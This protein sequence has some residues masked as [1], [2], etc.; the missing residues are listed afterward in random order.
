MSVTWSG[1]GT[2]PFGAGRLGVSHLSY[3]SWK[4]QILT[5]D[6]IFKWTQTYGHFISVCFTMIKLLNVN[7][8]SIPQLLIHV[9]AMLV[10]ILITSFY[11]ILLFHHHLLLHTLFPLHPL[12]S[13]CTYLLFAI[14]AVPKEKQTNKIQQN[15]KW[16]GP[17]SAWQRPSWKMG[18]IF[19]VNRGH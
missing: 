8:W 18:L 17:L 3:S 2:I 13:P 9:L 12:L 10:F 11:F 16:P 7:I 14:P 4:P 6:L 19:S 15:G 1:A 5:F